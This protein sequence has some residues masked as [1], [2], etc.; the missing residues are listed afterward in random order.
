MNVSLNI[1]S[2]RSG[3]FR[4]CFLFL[5]F[6]LFF[7]FCMPSGGYQIQYCKTALVGFRGIRSAA[8]EDLKNFY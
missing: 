5:F 1:D 2:V 4:V 6:F 8:M 3:C 7:F